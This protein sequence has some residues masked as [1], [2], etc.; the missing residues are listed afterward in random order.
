MIFD[1]KE[2]A[3]FDG[4]GMRQTVFLKGC[5]L[6]CQWCHNPEGLL[7]KTELMVS[8]ISC[9][10]CGQ[11]QKV[12]EHEA[13]I[14]CGNC[15]KV[16]PLRLRKITGL[17]LTSGELIQLIKE[18][19]EYYHRYGGGVTFSGGEPLM[20]TEFLLETLQGLEGIHKA[21]ETSGYAS[22]KSFQ[23]VVKRMDYVMM[24]IKLFDSQLHKKYIGT[25]NKQ[26]LANAKYLCN[27]STPFMIRIP[28]IPGVNDNEENYKNTAQWLAGAKALEKVELLPYH[29]T[30]G[31]KYT[32][33]GREY[34]PE[35]NTEQP[36]QI[37]NGIFEKYDIRSSVL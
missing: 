14:V 26:I 27:G 19:S 22:E 15:V 4:P 17:Q 29:K 37:I 20:Q 23:S 3:V 16:C 36:V 1:L 32:M 18:N 5:P 2:F 28:L 35:F 13:C 12:C 8:R 11:C 9:I 30:A 7:M 24:D 21:L 33:L 34:A 6:H 10:Q 31:A 25:D